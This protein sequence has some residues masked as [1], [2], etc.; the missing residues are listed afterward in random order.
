MPQQQQQVKAL[1]QAMDCEPRLQNEKGGDDYEVDC[2]SDG[3]G[4]CEEVVVN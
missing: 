1:V 2:E 3:S 4:S